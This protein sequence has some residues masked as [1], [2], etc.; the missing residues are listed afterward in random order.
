[1]DQA[2]VAHLRTDFIHTAANGPDAAQPSPVLA[3]AQAQALMSAEDNAMMAMIERAARDPAVD[4]EK[5]KDLWAM[6]REMLQQR[7]KM[8]YA[9]AFA[10]MQP[11]LPIV[12]E[13]GTITNTAGEVQSTYA[14]WEDINEAIKPVLK[15]FGFGLSFKTETTPANVTVTATL[16]HHGGHSESTTMTL[17]HDNSGKKNAVQQIASSVSYGKRY[18]AGALLNLTSRGEDDD[19]Q[20]GPDAQATVVSAACAAIALCHTEAQLDAW[21]EKN[22]GGFEGVPPDQM[23]VIYRTFNARRRAIIAGEA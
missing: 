11:E 21:K 4:M 6:R 5:M 2:T 15:K 19:G 1:M 3:I 9:A 18:T 20:G 23:K 14:F 8:A 16:D 22:E 10:A 13:N 7:A 12:A 17:P